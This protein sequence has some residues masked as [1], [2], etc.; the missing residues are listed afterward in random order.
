MDIFLYKRKKNSK[1]YIRLTIYQE[2]IFVS[3]FNKSRTILSS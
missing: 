2:H 1:S 3:L